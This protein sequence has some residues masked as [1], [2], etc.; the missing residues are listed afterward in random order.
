MLTVIVGGGTVGTELAVHLMKSGHDVS[1][2]EQDHA[3]CVELNDK[4]DCLVVEGA[5][6]S[7]RALAQAGIADANMVLAVTSMDEVNIMVCNIA[8]QY[9]VPT[10]IARIRCS[11]FTDRHSPV[12]VE[13]MGVTEVI[14]PERV[15]VRVID[16]IARI[17]G[18]VEV[19][20]Y[21]HGAILIARHIM[22][23][24]MPLLGKNLI[25]IT[26]MA[27][28]LEFL[29]V[30]LKRQTG[31]ARIPTGEDVIDAGDDV[32]TIFPEDSLPKYLDLLGLSGQR[33]RKAIISGTS[34]TAIQ[35][36]EQLSTWI[37]VVTLVDP[38]PQHAQLA[39]KR[40]NNVEVIHGDPSE[41]DLLREVNVDSAD[42]FVGA[43]QSTSLNVMSA[44][45]AKS[46]GA[47]RIMA[48]SFEPKS[49]RLFREIGVDHVISPRRAL[50]QEIL[51]IIYR[52]RRSVELQLRDMDLESVELMAQPG[53]RISRKPLTQ[54]WT[55]LRGQAI[56]GALIRDDKI[57]LPTGD[58]QVAEGD[59]VIVIVKP[60]SMAK[61]QKLFKQH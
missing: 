33:A 54:V 38:D 45:L 11:E 1:M 51:D 14:D 59:E 6:S 52:G 37:D 61:V 19:F 21:H 27:G 47:K 2:V 4:L 15:L 31:E 41:A 23:E 48:M 56:V 5:G 22:E 58:T 25:E 55:G 18:A 29:A 44:L 13:Q 8:A 30:A 24:G 10:R 46:E 49:N 20:S 26:K 3:H 39:A 36:A 32:T 57:L 42:L 16:Q 50:A 60:R 40:L 9:G 35:L 28:S 34:L 7:P 12:N 17:P 43:G 53:S